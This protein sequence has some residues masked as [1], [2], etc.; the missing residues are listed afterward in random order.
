MLVWVPG[1][2]M[3][4]GS[5]PSHPSGSKMR[6]VA[7]SSHLWVPQCSCDRTGAVWASFTSRALR[8]A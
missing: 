3:A 2:G 1:W 6:V 5:L 7:A 4:G 8:P